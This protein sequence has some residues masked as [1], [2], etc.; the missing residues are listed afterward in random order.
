MGS[1]SR[2]RVQMLKNLAPF[3]LGFP[4]GIGVATLLDDVLGHY[5]VWGGTQCETV[6]GVVGCF[7]YLP[8]GLLASI[9]AAPVLVQIALDILRGIRSRLSA[10]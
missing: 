3:L 5:I 8:V 7:G 6:N 4:L 1:L 10:E 9:I 2:H